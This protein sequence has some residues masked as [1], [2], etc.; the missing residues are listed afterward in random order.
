MKKKSLLALSLVAV[1]SISAFA[2]D[3]NTTVTKQGT[4]VV[5]SMQQENCDINRLKLAV[6]KLINKVTILEKRVSDLEGIKKVEIS[7][8]MV[9]ATEN[10]DKL[11]NPEKYKMV[12]TKKK[13]RV[14]HKYT[15]G[16]IEGSF[17]KFNKPKEFRAGVDLY[18]YVEP[19]LYAKHTD[20][21]LFKR[22]QKFEGDMWTYAGW[23]HVKGTKYWVKGY[24]LVPKVLQKKVP[25]KYKVVEDCKKVL[26][27]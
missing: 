12:C 26:V 4:G 27:K 8:S 16:E 7:S 5:K 3:T 10:L 6:N 22:G 25:G 19:V 17:I 1:M 13:V 2:A 9:S 24:K 20:K 21:P 23:I 14:S 15:V 18:G 11:V